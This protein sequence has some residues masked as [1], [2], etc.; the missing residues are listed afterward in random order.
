MARR[1]SSLL[2]P[3]RRAES[4]PPE[5]SCLSLQRRVLAP[6]HCRNL[7]TSQL[8]V[9]TRRSLPV[10]GPCLRSLRREC[11]AETTPWCLA[12]ALSYLLQLGSG[13]RVAHNRSL[14]RS[15]PS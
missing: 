9:G 5:L 4:S 12:A 3:L 8:P 15:S 11:S 6:Q 7:L 14:I 13:N 2:C 10:T 1:N